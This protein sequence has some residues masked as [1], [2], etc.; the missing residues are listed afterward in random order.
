MIRFCI[1]CKKKFSYDVNPNDN[2]GSRTRKYCDRCV[3]LQHADESR[4]Y[5]RLRRQK[6]LL[7]LR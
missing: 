1:R 4:L 6:K 7:E 2:R 3:I 5:Q